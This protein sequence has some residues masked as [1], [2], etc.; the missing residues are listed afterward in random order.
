MDLYVYSVLFRQKEFKNPK[1]SP[2]SERSLEQSF[3][4]RC[5]Y[6]CIFGPF[7][8]H[9]SSLPKLQA[10]LL[11]CWNKGLWHCAGNW[12][13]ILGQVRSNF[14]FWLTWVSS[15]VLRRIV[16][17]CFKLVF[18]I[19]TL[20]ITLCLFLPYIPWVVLG[21]LGDVILKKKGHKKQLEYHEYPQLTVKPS[22]LMFDL[23]TKEVVDYFQLRKAGITRTAPLLSFRVPKC[24]LAG[25]SSRLLERRLRKRR[26]AQM[27]S[28][29]FFMSI[30]ALLD[31]IAQKAD[32]C[33]R[34]ARWY[35][36]PL[37]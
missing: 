36:L 9:C 22:S 30:C 16:G 15:S 17:S 7:F 12:T 26:S 8:S 25:T 11:L 33:E 34:S 19:K 10:F 28:F 13:G 3:Q 6:K 27:K 31:E 1:T 35:V 21:I 14:T 4:Q 2:L 29:Y 32:G 20:F 37:R 23:L 5:L 18:P 24:P